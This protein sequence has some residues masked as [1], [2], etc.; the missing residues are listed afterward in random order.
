MGDA[1]NS[2][3]SWGLSPGGATALQQARAGDVEAFGIVCLELENALWRQS[4]WLCPDDATAED[5]VQEALLIAWRK[6]DRFDGSSRFLTWVM[7]I[8]FNLHRNMA[9]KKQLV[10]ESE[11]KG[12]DGNAGE[13]PGSLMLAL[14]DPGRGPADS[15]LVAERNSLLRKCLGR[16]SDEQRSVVQLRFFL[17]ADLSEIAAVLGC[18]AGTVKSRL[19]HAIRKLAAMDD[20]RETVFGT[21][22]GKLL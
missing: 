4:L 5:L 22:L 1:S 19:F 14:V 2:A 3:N 15:L 10:L 16:L 9:R 20:L 6:L 11:L 12:S 18:P 13:P 21:N 17:G 7:G 8:L